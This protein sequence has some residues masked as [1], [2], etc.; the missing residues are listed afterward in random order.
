M[1]GTVLWLM[2]CHNRQFSLASHTLR[3]EL[4]EA[5]VGGGVLQAVCLARLCNVR[6]VQLS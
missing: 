1:D 3:R 5:E 6:S 4:R 2:A